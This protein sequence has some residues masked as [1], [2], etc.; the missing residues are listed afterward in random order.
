[1]TASPQQAPHV[2]RLSAGKT[3]PEILAD[4]LIPLTALGPERNEAAQRIDH[5]ARLRPLYA[6][7]RLQNAVKALRALDVLAV[8]RAGK[9][10]DDLHRPPRR[11]LDDFDSAAGLAEDGCLDVTLAEADPRPAVLA[12]ELVRPPGRTAPDQRE[13]ATRPSM[14]TPQRPAG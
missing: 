1:M 7:P 5:V 14:D 11:A 13:A 8:L 6:W 4:H 12:G 9:T 10:V 3:S 2:R